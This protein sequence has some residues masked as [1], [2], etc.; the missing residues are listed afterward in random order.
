MI[1]NWQEDLRCRSGDVPA[2]L[3]R[4]LNSR[5]ITRWR[6]PS[7]DAGSLDNSIEW[8]TSQPTTS[9]PLG[10]LS[11]INCH[12]AGTPRR[13]A[14]VPRGLAG[15]SRR[16]LLFRIAFT[17]RQLVVAN[18]RRR[19]RSTQPDRRSQPA[20]QPTHAPRWF[21]HRP[22]TSASVHG[23]NV[24]VGH[25]ARPVSERVDLSLSKS[26]RQSGSQNLQVASRSITSPIG[27]ISS[28]RTKLRFDDVRKYLEHGKCDTQTDAIRP[29][30][31]VLIVASSVFCR[32]SPIVAA[33]PTPKTLSNTNVPWWSATM[34]LTIASPSPVP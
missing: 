32:C 28:R 20:V 31:P 5:R 18:Q 3:C 25:D 7:I 6:M 8:A 12:W 16:Q 22:C 24:G 23:G 21:T 27:P 1:T 29:E 30:V 19:Q 10:D 11:A 26:L 4:G 33:V 17:M 9:A 15:Q 14:R 34:R 13:R 2:P